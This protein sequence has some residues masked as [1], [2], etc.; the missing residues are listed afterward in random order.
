MKK[1]DGEIQM[2]VQ[3]EIA[4]SIYSGFIDCEGASLEEYRPKLLIND[5]ESGQKVLTNII[6]ELNHC[7]EFFFSGCVYHPKRSDGFTEY[8]KRA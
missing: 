6:K 4:K 8:F 2:N 7:D 5:Y 1:T 3:G